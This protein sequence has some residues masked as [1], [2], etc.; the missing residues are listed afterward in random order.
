M[1]L[2]VGSG[3]PFRYSVYWIRDLKKVVCCPDEG[4]DLRIELPSSRS[5][6]IGHGDFAYSLSQLG[7]S[8]L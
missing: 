1:R 7:G 6:W 8:A 3:V 4:R 5:S 2:A